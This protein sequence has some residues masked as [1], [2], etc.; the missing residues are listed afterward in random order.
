[1][2]IHIIFAREGS[3]GW[4][5]ESCFYW[6]YYHRQKNKFSIFRR[7][8]PTRRDAMNCARVANPSAEFVVWNAASLDQPPNIITPLPHIVAV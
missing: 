8:F 5:T 4:C 7:P 6:L 3:T 1:M 2:Q